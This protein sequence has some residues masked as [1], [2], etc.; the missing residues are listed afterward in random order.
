M[1]SYAREFLLSGLEM[2]RR[3]QIGPIGERLG[4][5][6]RDLSLSD[7]DLAGEDHVIVG[8][9]GGAR[10]ASGDH[11]F[12]V[13]L[14][15]VLL[16]SCLEGEPAAASG[17]LGLTTPKEDEEGGTD[18]AAALVGGVADSSLVSS[19]QTFFFQK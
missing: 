12:L 18:G 16:L 10:C 8:G 2:G 13:C 7:L 17:P 6:D 9:H 15:Y 11:D 5:L 1:D 3:D 14:C 4:K 19:S